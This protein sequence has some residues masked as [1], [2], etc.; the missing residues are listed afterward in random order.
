MSRP[1]SQFQNAQFCWRSRKAKMLTTG[2]YVIF[3]GLEFAPDAEIE[4]KGVF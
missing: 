1:V 4:Q 2:I 3:R